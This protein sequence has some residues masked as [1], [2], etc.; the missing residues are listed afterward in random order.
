MTSSFRIADDLAF[1]VSRR[2]VVVVVNEDT[3]QRMAFYQSSGRNGGAVAGQ[4]VPFHGFCTGWGGIWFIKQESGKAA[5]GW[6]ADAAAWLAD[7]EL[8]A[9]TATLDLPWGTVT[10]QLRLQTLAHVE[11]LNGWLQFAGVPQRTDSP[12]LAG[13]AAGQLRADLRR[14]A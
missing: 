7:A 2:R 11:Q 12:R 1:T 10:P 6:M 9:D 5:Q 13:A 14:A 3:E 4:W 8:P